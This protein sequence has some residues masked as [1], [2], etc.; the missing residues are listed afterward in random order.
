MQIFIFNLANSRMR[1]FTSGVIYADSYP[2]TVFKFNFNT[3]DWDISPTKTAVF[4]YRGKNYRE[5][6]DENNMCRVP[7]EVLHEG[8]FL[9]SV[10]DGRGL[11]TN[12][13][14]VPVSP[15]PGELAPDIP[16]GNCDCGP[17]MV[18]VPTVDERKILSWTIQEATDDM[19]VPPPT[20]LN[21]NDEWLPTGNEV[22]SEYI[23]EPMQ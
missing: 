16:G 4:S 15:M 1:R 18:Y 12:K 6:L 8:Y 19:P 9:V 3:P 2:N 11:L 14:R 22:E 10:E 20:D 17:S 23:W 7:E 21:P 13:I 5:P